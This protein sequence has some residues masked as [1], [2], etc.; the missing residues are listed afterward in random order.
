MTHET[1][2]EFI[3][4]IPCS[5]CS[6]SDGCAVYD[7]GHMYCFS[8]GHYFPSDDE[9]GSPSTSDSQKDSKGTGGFLDGQP[10]E[11]VKRGISYETCR[12]FDYL[13]GTKGDTKVQIANFYD[14]KRQLVFQKIRDS[15]KNF[16]AR[17]NIKLAPLFGQHLWKEGGKKIVITEGEI[18][19]LSVSQAQGN[20]WPVVSI[21]N[22]T[23]GAAKALKRQLEF[24]ES[25]DEV[26]LM[27]DNDE[28]GREAV[29]ECVEL[30]TPGK[31]RVAKLEGAKDPNELL[32]AG[33]S[34]D[35]ITA[36]WQARPWT[37]DGVVNG[38]DMWDEVTKPVQWG[39]SYPWESITHAT[40]GIRPNEIITL[41]AG[42]GMGKTEFFKE[43]CTHMVVEHKQNIGVLF[44]EEANR[45]TALGIMGKHASVPFHLPDVEFTEE[46]KREAYDATMG[47]GRVF[48]YDSFGYTD[49]EIIKSRIR[50]MVV[51][52]GCKTIFL[53]HI[54][55]LVSGG[56]VLDERRELDAIM[57][58]LASL[59]REL[60]VT[61]F[62]ISHLS[63]PEGKPHE[64][65][66]RVQIKHF[67]GSRAI[68]QWSSFMIG[69][70]RNQ[71]D[72]EEKGI[73][74]FR[75]LKDRY[76][77]RATGFTTHF[78]YDYETGRLFEHMEN[79]FDNEEERGGSKDEPDF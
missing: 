79:P 42:T 44:L 70:E 25:Y 5:E 20:K 11:L 48:L 9:Q 64:E 73:T 18:D 51:S 27:F 22:G 13:V 2:A 46:Q 33:K 66:G 67:R 7:D 17:G 4:H 69:L 54:T 6:S 49:Y 21:P 8:C 56:A 32:V 65:G 39:L 55:A 75:I 50:Y 24:L 68:G 19:A 12:K 10:K 71:Q 47:T 53:D 40:Y 60:N 57:T 35:I 34:S 77:G 38:L 16:S 28:A 78:G 74:T 43:L 58:D 41:G 3:E 31:V 76:S 61:L 26:I 15:K 72:E 63:T 23:K 29:E 37:P 45:D 62:L 59:V 14:A 52:C 36:I 30:F 1:D